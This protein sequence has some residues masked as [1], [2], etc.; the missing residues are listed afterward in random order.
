LSDWTA[1][2]TGVV[3]TEPWWSA[4]LL[5]NAFLLGAALGPVAARFERPGAAF[6]V[7]ETAPVGLAALRAATDRGVAFAALG[8]IDTAHAVATRQRSFVQITGSAQRAA[9]VTATCVVNVL[10]TG[11]CSAAARLP[12]IETGIAAARTSLRAVRFAVTAGIAYSE[13]GRATATIAV[14]TA[15]FTA[16]TDTSWLAAF[17]MDTLL[18]RTLRRTSAFPRGKGSAVGSDVGR[19]T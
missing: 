8:A 7:S 18:W 5:V 2:R 16:A 4:A 11:H 14:G 1:E 17:T 3:A 6:P 12:R 10:R 13:T 19:L 15:L 9:F